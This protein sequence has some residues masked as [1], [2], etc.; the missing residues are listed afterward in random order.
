MFS[1]PD[2][3]SA[4]DV[5]GLV[6]NFVNQVAVHIESDLFFILVSDAR[7]DMPFVVVYSKARK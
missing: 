2:G 6:V 4:V 7:E 5:F 1:D 3:L